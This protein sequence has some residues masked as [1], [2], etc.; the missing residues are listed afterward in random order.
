MN[1]LMVGTIITLV[2]VGIMNYYS[3]LLGIIVLIIGVSIG[4]K[5]RNKLD[6]NE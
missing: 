1:Y 3:K 2:A 4:I 5:G 6:K